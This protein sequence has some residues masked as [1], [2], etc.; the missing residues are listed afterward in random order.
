MAAGRGAPWSRP[1]ACRD[2][3]G[4]EPA[5]GA[6]GGGARAHPPGSRPGE[7][8]S[9]A[10]SGTEWGQDWKENLRRNWDAVVSIGIQGESLPYDDQFMDLDPAYRDSFGL[11]SFA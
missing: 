1:W 6:N 3:R 11:P 9:L 4:T 5:Q 7:V 2:H 8:S 10:G